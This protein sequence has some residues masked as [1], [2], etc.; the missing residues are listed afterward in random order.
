MP[1]DKGMLGSVILVTGGTGSFGQAFVKQILK[2]DVKAVRIYSRNEY[3]Q[4]QMRQT[5]TDNRIRWM[6]GDVRDRDRLE[7]CLKGVDYVIHAAAL[8]HLSIGQYNPQEFIKTNVFGS[9]NLVDIAVKMGVKKILGI[10]SDKAVSPS[11]LYGSTKQN[12]EILFMDANRWSLPKT[13]FSCFRSGNFFES[14]GNVFELW[15][16]QA[17]QGEIT[18][19]AED[20]YRYFISVADVAKLAINCLGFMQGQEIFI[21][22]MR[23][24][25]ILD[26]ARE[27]YPDCKLKIIGK[28]QG[29]KLHE[30]LYGEDEVVIDKG[31]YWVIENR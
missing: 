17:K 23:E 11:S 31:E 13:A 27:R 10:S 6:L 2:Y 22:K 4:W 26:L 15:A 16:L 1:E 28:L 20:M 9:M 7:S 24:F 5:F 14:Q 12:M 29:E 21:P 25:S 30:R 8:K 3:L 19:T 18:I